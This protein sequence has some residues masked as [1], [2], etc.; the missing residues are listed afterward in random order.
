LASRRREGN[1]PGCVGSQEPCGRRRWR[2]PCVGRRCG[3]CQGESGSGASLGARNCHGASASL[4]RWEFR[5]SIVSSDRVLR[6]PAIARR[7][8]RG[9]GTICWDRRE[10]GPMDRLLCAEQISAQTP[11]GGNGRKPG[12]AVR[13]GCR[14]LRLR[15]VSVHG[16]G[17][18]FGRVRRC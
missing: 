17:Q 5:R 13:T 10:T 12:S 4:V 7:G 15:M 14:K 9:V 8:F 18:A 11:D 1:R 16:G 6:H 3:L 2:P